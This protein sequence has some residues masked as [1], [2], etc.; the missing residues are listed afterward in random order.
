MNCS[1]RR[2]AKCEIENKLIN[3]DL[4]AIIYDVQFTFES[5]RPIICEFSMQICDYLLNVLL[6]RIQFVSFQLFFVHSFALIALLSSPLQTQ[7]F[8]SGAYFSFTISGNA[9]RDAAGEK[10]DFK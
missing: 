6:D 3:I 7:N 9:E 10:E 8:V 4:I 1:V 2:E 5:R